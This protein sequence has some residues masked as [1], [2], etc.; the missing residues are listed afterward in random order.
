M[1]PFARAT[2]DSFGSIVYKMPSYR[3]PA[4]EI[5]LI[6][7]PRYGIPPLMAFSALMAIEGSDGTRYFGKSQLGSGATNQNGEAL[8]QMAL[9]S[10]SF[11]EYS[12]RRMR[13]SVNKFAVQGNGGSESV[14]HFFTSRDRR[15]RR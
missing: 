5:R 11:P 15:K 9:K 4:F 1:I 7:L 3:M 2:V 6:L 10:N 8:R 12:T 13:A 14:G